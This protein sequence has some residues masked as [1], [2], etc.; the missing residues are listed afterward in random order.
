MRWGWWPR[1]SPATGAAAAG[2]AVKAVTACMHLH[3]HVPIGQTDGNCEMD[4]GVWSTYGLDIDLFSVHGSS[5][6]EYDGMHV[7]PP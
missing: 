5:M 6:R 4:Y 1:E 3:V 7:Q 2:T